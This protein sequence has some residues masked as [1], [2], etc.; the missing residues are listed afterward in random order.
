MR[1]RFSPRA[2][3]DLDAISAYIRAR[4]PAAAIRVRAAILAMIETLALFPYAGR[5]QTTEGMRKLV[6]PK[7]P[8]IVYFTVDDAAETI[9][10]VTIRH[11]ARR[12]EHRD[13]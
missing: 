8:Y 1:V 12:R 4:N 5:R 11:G 10:I 7:Y 6:V 13:A 9:G 3:R 2:V